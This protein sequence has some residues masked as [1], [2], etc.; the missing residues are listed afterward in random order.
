MSFNV[1]FKVNE[2][3]EVIE[4]AHENMIFKELIRNF[5]QKVGLKDEHKASFTFNSEKIKTDSKRK[6]KYL[7]I[8]E[9]SVINVKTVKP[10][11][12]KPEKPENSKNQLFSI[13]FSLNGVYAGS[14]WVNENM[15][16]SEV[17]FHFFKNFPMW[18]KN[19]TTFFYNLNLIKSDS[20]KNL[21]ELGIKNMSKIEVKTNTPIDNSLNF[22][23]EN[24]NMNKNKSSDFDIKISV[25]GVNVFYM[26]VVENMLFCEVVYHFCKNFSLKENEASFFFNS[27]EIKSDSTKKLR[28]LGIKN[29]ST[30]DVKTKTPINY[31]FNYNYGR[32]GMNSYSYMGLQNYKNMNIDNQ[33]LSRSNIHNNSEI[34]VL[35]ENEEYLNVIFSFEGKKINIQATKYTKFSELS[36]RFCLLDEIKGKYP[37][38]LINSK[39]IRPNDNDNITLDKVKIRNNMMI[40]VVF[41]GE[42]IA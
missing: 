33:T 21:K 36:K 22:N 13:V 42:V 34:S 18:H 6:L 11:D 29:M 24:M 40:D 5:N 8:V 3:L 27:K 30:I 2:N 7:G 23:Y 25:N 20:T 28:K 16:F 31:P 17:T 35:K 9:N 15:L 26:H 4:S 12:Y 41:E 10:L 37:V 32:M 14:M 39:S 38:Y 1:K 19:E